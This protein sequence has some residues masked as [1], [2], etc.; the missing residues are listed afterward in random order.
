MKKMLFGM[1]AVSILVVAAP[2]AAQNGSGTYGSQGNSYQNQNGGNIVAR[3]GQLQTRIQLGMQSGLITRQEAVPLR[4]QLRV[5]V[6][7]ERQYRS[8][9][10]TGQERADL[11]QRLR[12]LRQ[13]VRAADGGA[14]GR[15]DQYDR[16]DDMYGADRQYGN[17]AMIDQNR[18]GFDDRDYNRNGRWDDDANS[19]GYNNGGYNNGTYQQPAPRSGLGGLIDSVLGTRGLRV[20]QQVSGNLS[21]VPYQYQNQFRDGNGVYYRSDG[22]QIY[23]ID[24][25]T[26]TVVRVYSIGQ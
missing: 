13:Q 20:G 14:R 23:Q 11:Q 7:L 5:L 26:Q 6:Q 25:R 1:A 18:D 15:Y 3:I 2:A 12:S 19:G 22:R 10:L 16:Q 24:A 21:P 17:D 4:Q 8:N 9:G